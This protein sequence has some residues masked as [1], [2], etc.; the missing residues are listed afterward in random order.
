MVSYE[1]IIDAALPTFLIISNIHGNETIG[2]YIIQSFISE[3]EEGH[4]AEFDN[5]INFIIIPSVNPDGFFANTR[6]TAT[7]IDPNRDYVAD[8]SIETTQFKQYFES[9]SNKYNMCLSI[10]LHGGALCVSYP[11]DAHPQK[12]N[13]YAKSSLD[14]YYINASKVYAQNHSTM[15][16]QYTYNGGYINGA[17]WYHIDGSIQDWLVEIG[18]PSITLELSRVKNPLNV[19]VD[20][21]EL[22]MASKTVVASFWTQN[23]MA[24]LQLI[25]YCIDNPLPVRRK[26]KGDGAAFTTRR[27]GASPHLTQFVR[28]VCI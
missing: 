3:L 11:L 20:A 24:L 14:E 9:I 27:K 8:Q 18:V 6:H 10:H 23:K 7:M 4:Y 22:P 21:S 12:L 16:D 5:K 26:A 25:Q 19:N 15:V 17:D 13:K 2:Y 1:Y 28:R